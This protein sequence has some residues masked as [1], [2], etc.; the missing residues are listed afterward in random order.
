LLLLHFS[1]AFC[2]AIILKGVLTDIMTLTNLS[3]H[4]LLSNME[5][6]SNYKATRMLGVPNS[7]LQNRLFS[8]VIWR[9][10]IWTTTSIVY[11]SRKQSLLD[12]SGP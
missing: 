4:I 1:P 2:S 6:M 7:T 5:K 8:K 9:L 11:R 3:M 10:K 12:T